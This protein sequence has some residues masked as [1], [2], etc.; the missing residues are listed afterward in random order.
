VHRIM[1][2][3]LTYHRHKPKVDFYYLSLLNVPSNTGNFSQIR[4]KRGFTVLFCKV[5][6]PKHSLHCRL[7]EIAYSTYS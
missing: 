1:I 7:P 2:V 5:G 4:E 3:T 6:S